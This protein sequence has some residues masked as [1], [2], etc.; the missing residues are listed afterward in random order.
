MVFHPAWRHIR[1]HQD[2]RIVLQGEV[3]QRMGGLRRPSGCGDGASLGWARRRVRRW[4]KLYIKAM[5]RVACRSRPRV[6]STVIA[7]EPVGV[8]PAMLCAVHRGVGMIKQRVRFDAVVRRKT[9]P[10]AGSYVK[11]VP[12]SINPALIS[13]RIFWATAAAFV[14][15]PISCRITVNS[16]PA[17]RATRSSSRVQRRRQAATSHNI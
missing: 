8:L 11:H 12:R 14:A 10:D 9:D 6:H 2:T 1:R 3:G 17:S 4:G 7:E 15:N 13:P 5:P 16:S